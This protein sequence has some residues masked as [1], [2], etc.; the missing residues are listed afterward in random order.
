VRPGIPVPITATVSP[1]WTRAVLTTAPTPVMT[2]QPTG[3]ACPA[4][5]GGHDAPRH[6]HVLS[7]GDVGELVDRDVPRQPRLQ[8]GQTAAGW[9]RDAASSTQSRRCRRTARRRTTVALL[10]V[11]DASTSSTTPAAS[12][13]ST[14]GSGVGRPSW[15]RSLPDAAR[16]C[17]RAPAVAGIAHVDLLNLG[18]SFTLRTAASR[19]FLIAVA[20]SCPLPPEGRCGANGGV[21]D[22]S[23]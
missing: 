12:W 20:E 11:G 13:P 2:E 21:G 19:P 3:A 22:R 8:A 18:G 17:G 4:S 1:G 9:C 23:Y 5:S 16:R 15:C 10:D 6:E 14:I 7:G